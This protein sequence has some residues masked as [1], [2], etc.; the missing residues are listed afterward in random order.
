MFTIPEVLSIG[1]FVLPLH[2]I[3]LAFLGY[4]STY[5]VYLKNKK[6]GFSHEQWENVLLSGIV[7]YIMV[8][9]FSLIIISPLSVFENPLLL[10]YGSGGFVGSILGIIAGTVTLIVKGRKGSYPFVLFL[11]LL[12]FW[13]IILLT[14][15]W[16]LIPSYGS[17][18]T[19]PW[20]VELGNSTLTYHPLHWYVFL[21]GS[22]LLSYL[23]FK[24]IAFGSGKY[25][26][27]ALF[28]FSLGLLF[29]SNFSIKVGSYS[30]LTP[31]QWL[32]LCFSLTGF[33]SLITLNRAKD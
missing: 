33:I 10:L 5:F 31:I 11:D 30:L 18:T 2:Y 26:S 19:L 29:I 17:Q 20:G 4:V 32:Y 8:W 24:K 22:L 23:S 15:Y 16:T 14:A 3:L 28:L 9:K 6:L 1:S 12:M 25:A 13:V 21:M 27:L 7:T